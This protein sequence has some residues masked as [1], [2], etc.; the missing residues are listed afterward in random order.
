MELAA[1]RSKEDELVRRLGVEGGA[2]RLEPIGHDR[3]WNRYW[4]LGKWTAAESGEPFMKRT[5]QIY[6][7]VEPVLSTLFTIGSII[8]E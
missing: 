6:Y 2:V 5:V 4:I 3:V 7:T 8:K 1:C